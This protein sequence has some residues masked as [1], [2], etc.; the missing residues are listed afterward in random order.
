MPSLPAM[1]SVDTFN[2]NYYMKF[3]IQNQAKIILLDHPIYQ[4]CRFFHRQ[5][6]IL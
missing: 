5:L 4:H 1:A 2:T 6:A 3:I